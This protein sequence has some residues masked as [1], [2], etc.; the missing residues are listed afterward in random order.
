MAL[1]DLWVV[2]NH[3]LRENYNV[4]Q[5]MRASTSAKLSVKDQL[6][7]YQQYNIVLYFAS[8]ASRICSLM[9][10]V[11]NWVIEGLNSKERLPKYVLI[12]LDKDLIDVTLRYYVQRNSF[13]CSRV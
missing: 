10:R 7:I 1:K 13:F 8:G 12:M 4:L 5:D 2:G 11:I 3:F 6:Y 9:A